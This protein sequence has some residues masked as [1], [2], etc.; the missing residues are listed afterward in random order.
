MNSDFLSSSHDYRLGFLRKR[1]TGFPET[2]ISSVNPV[3]SSPGF[4]LSASVLLPQ[5]IILIRTEVMG[6]EKCAF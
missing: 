5:D 1:G 3:I 4:S 6:E 2:G